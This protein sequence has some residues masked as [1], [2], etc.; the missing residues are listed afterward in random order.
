M[1]LAA[2]PEAALPSTSPAFAEVRAS[3]LEGKSRAARALLD[4]RKPVP[5]GGGDVVLVAEVWACTGA[6]QRAA[7]ILRWG[8]RCFGTDADVDVVAA[9]SALARGHDRFAKALLVDRPGRARDVLRARI[10]LTALEPAA[11]DDIDAAVDVVLAQRD[12]TRALALATAALARAPTSSRARLVCARMM[13]AAGQLD[14]GRAL[15]KEATRSPLEDA[16][17]E[18]ALALALV[19]DEKHDEAGL[20]AARLRSR[21]PDLAGERELRF[22]LTMLA[23]TAGRPDDAAAVAAGGTALL[24]AEAAAAVFLHGGPAAADDV[25]TAPP[26]APRPHKEVSSA[27][28]KAPSFAVFEAPYEEPAAWR[29]PAAIVALVLSVGVIG[30]KYLERSH[31]ELLPG[32]LVDDV[33]DAGPGS[34]GH[35]HPRDVVVDAGPPPFQ[36]RITGEAFRS[37]AYACSVTI[38]PIVDIGMPFANIAPALVGKIFNERRF[39]PARLPLPLDVD[40]LGRVGVK[41]VPLGTGGRVEP[42]LILGQDRGAGGGNT[43]VVIGYALFPATEDRPQVAAVVDVGRIPLSVPALALCPGSGTCFRSTGQCEGVDVVVR[44]R[45]SSDAPLKDAAAL[46]PCLIDALVVTAR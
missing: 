14:E 9:R 30:F 45:C 28:P 31:A 38:P 40:L 7:A 12:P 33:V 43:D 34:A 24:P 35:P 41:F 15:L 44:G 4:E 13:R 8:S 23:W 5:K 21:H 3:F 22:L 37:L 11:D 16:R 18:L 39:S 27:V 32:F 6:F 29:R 42:A 46:G 25:A 1:S 36:P 19:A 26:R 17:L 2:R 20:A 10:A